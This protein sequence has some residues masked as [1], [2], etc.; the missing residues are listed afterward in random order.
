MYLNTSSLLK[1]EESVVFSLLRA[2]IGGD[3][4]MSERFPTLLAILGKVGAV[5]RKH[6]KPPVQKIVVH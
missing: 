1:D 5:G 6:H 2:W 4:G 3:G